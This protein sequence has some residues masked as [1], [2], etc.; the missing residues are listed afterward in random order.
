MTTEA[1]LLKESLATV[2]GMAAELT[3]YFYARLFMENPALRSMF[4]LVM[5][6]QRDRLLQALVHIVQS[7]ESPETLIPY[8]Q[9][10]GRDHRK[11]GVQPEHYEA[12]GAALLGAVREYSSQ[13]WT[14]EIEDAWRNAYGVAARTMIEAAALD[15]APPWWNAEVIGHE[16]RTDEIAVLYVRP[17]QPYP[18]EPGQYC[19]LETTYQPRVWRSYSMANAPRPDNVLEF[20]VRALGLGWVSGTL[21][22]KVNVGDTLRLGPPMGSMVLDRTSTRDLVCVGGSTG[23]GP[24]KALIEE[25]ARHSTTG[26]AHLFFGV[27]DCADLYDVAALQDMANRYPW[28]TLVTCVSDDDRYAG[29]QGS[30]PDVLARH[31]SWYHHDVYAAGSPHMVSATLDR[32]KELGVPSGR[33]KYDVVGGVLSGS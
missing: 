11:F 8:L 5:D 30:L 13:T 12:V 20:H 7:I 32:L 4:P 3:A 9:Q 2:S 6:V 29:E 31:G 15:D 17:D 27:R 22:R 16:R 10:L 19:S 1:K 25:Y 21:V 33:I 23:V 26:R 24:M 18:F 28:L 14:S